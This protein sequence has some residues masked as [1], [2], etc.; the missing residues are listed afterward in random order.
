MWKITEAALT[1]VGWAFI[2]W[3]LMTLFSPDP[4]GAPWK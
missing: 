1:M 2:L 3:I 4:I